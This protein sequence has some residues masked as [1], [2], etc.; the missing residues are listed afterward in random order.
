MAAKNP[1]TVSVKST[2]YR[3]SSA[4]RRAA[5]LAAVSGQQAEL[6]REAAERAAKRALST[7]AP[8]ASAP[9]KSATARRS[10]AR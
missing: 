10:N 2:N 8:A 3:P 5:Q 7:D 6:K 4:E 1:V 9:R